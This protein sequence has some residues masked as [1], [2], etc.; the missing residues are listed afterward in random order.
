MR[1]I[2]NFAERKK[3][4]GKQRETHGNERSGVGTVNG[5]PMRRY[6]GS[7]PSKPFAVCKYGCIEDG[8]AE[9]GSETGGLDDYRHLS[10]SEE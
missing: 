8:R 10:L 3:K 5:V 4:R 2:S 1:A 6:F 7:S 9:L